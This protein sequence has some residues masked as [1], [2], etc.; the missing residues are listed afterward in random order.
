MAFLLV[1]ILGQSLVN[2]KSIYLQHMRACSYL[3]L[4]SD[5]YV[6]MLSYPGFFSQ[7]IDMGYLLD[8]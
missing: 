8:V 1:L 3:N 5:V 6:R 2:P 7:E 4:H